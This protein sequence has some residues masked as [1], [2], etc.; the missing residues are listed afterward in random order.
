MTYQRA[1]PRANY[2]LSSYDDVGTS[3]HT[4]ARWFDELRDG[5]LGFSN[6]FY[7]GMRRLKLASDFST[8]KFV[9]IHDQTADIVTQ[10]DPSVQTLYPN[11]IEGDYGDMNKSVMAFYDSHVEYLEVELGAPNTPKYNLH[12]VMTTDKDDDDEP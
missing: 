9:W 6:A 8:S 3:Y 7:E 1:W 11:G 10:E 2:E 4:N 5:G 12:L